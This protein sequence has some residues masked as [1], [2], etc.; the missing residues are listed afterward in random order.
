ME[1]QNKRVHRRVNS[2]NLLAYVCLDP[3]NEVV[4]QGM[5]RTLNVSQSGILLETHQP[6][7]PF[8]QVM[9]TIGLEEDLIDIRGKIVYSRNGAE[10]KFETGIHFID[11]AENQ[12][13]LLKKYI[14]AFGKAEEL[15]TEDSRLKAEG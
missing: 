12:I 1:S 14:A 9:L 13:E 11:V 2:L 6:L 5:G 15:Q 7:D 4:K 3:D 10:G 8:Y